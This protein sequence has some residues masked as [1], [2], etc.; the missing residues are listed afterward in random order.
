M[1]TKDVVY[2]AM[3]AALTAAFAVFPPLTLPATGVPI[4]AQS[5]GP[6]LAGA[7][8]GWRRAV[9]SQVLFL[10]L[11]AAGLPLLAGGRGGLGVFLGPSGGFLVGWILAAL[12]IGWTF[13]RYWEVLNLASALALV[14]LG[15]VIVEYP[16]GNAW[17]S[18]V[19][20]LSYL[21]ATIA[22]AAFLPGD[23]L[24]VVAASGI[25]MTVRRS[26][27]LM[28]AAAHA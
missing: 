15:G 9:A 26:Y 18:I 17:V 1:T 6:M 14:F 3:F 8:L 4:T 10:A 19:T 11:V 5:L 21:E 23:I 13:E 28:P 27:P 24:K 7:V 12:V 25:A 2:V 16:I 22:S 20:D